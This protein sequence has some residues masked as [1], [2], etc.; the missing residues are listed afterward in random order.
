MDEAVVQ[1]G[2]WVVR[3]VLAG[4][5]KQGAGWGF[6]GELSVS[7]GGALWGS[8][9][10]HLIVCLKPSDKMRVEVQASHEIWSTLLAGMTRVIVIEADLRV[11]S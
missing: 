8:S 3:S 6:G 9:T 11:L 2:E 1:L 4:P 5:E 7:V 10:C